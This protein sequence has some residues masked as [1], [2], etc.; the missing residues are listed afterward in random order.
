MFGT[1]TSVDS[2]V[3]ASVVMQSQAP[4]IPTGQEMMEVPQTSA[5]SG[6]GARRDVG[7]IRHAGRHDRCGSRNT[8]NTEK[9]ILPKRKKGSQN[10]SDDVESML[11][12]WVTRN[13]MASPSRV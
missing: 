11:Q 12:H 5:A 4:T 10:P 8:H 1:A 2:T 13:A 3:D 6:I 9:E 7:K